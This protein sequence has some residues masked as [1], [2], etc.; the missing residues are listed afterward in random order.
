[1]PLL[2]GHRLLQAEQGP[3]SPGV[4][5][6]PLFSARRTKWAVMPAQDVTLG[7]NCTELPK[8][9]T[10]LFRLCRTAR[11]PFSS[12]LR[13]TWLWSQSTAEPMS[14]AACIQAEGASQKRG[15]KSLLVA[16]SPNRQLPKQTK[17]FCTLSSSGYHTAITAV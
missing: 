2:H 5:I 8:V 3:S 9:A 12:E 13:T 14:V 6:L 1:M 16:C 11:Q 7:L 10:I 4:L 15:R 17:S